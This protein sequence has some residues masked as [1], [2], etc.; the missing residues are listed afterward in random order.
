MY[1]RS[2]MEP[3]ARHRAEERGPSARRQRE[4]E[5]LRHQ[6]LD[7][8]ETI[9]IEEGYDHL[10]MRRLAEAI[11]YAP[12]TLYGYFPDKK[13]ILQAVID[14]T[15]GYL[16]EALDRAATTPGPL[17]RL[18]MLGRAYVEFALEYPKHYEVLFLRRGPTVPLIVS[19]AFT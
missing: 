13:A 16:L 14:R 7:A 19:P 1:Y 12:S 2:V 18:R 10:S 11:E 15:T 4:I 8:A 6:I 17:T 9:L 5:A 3:P